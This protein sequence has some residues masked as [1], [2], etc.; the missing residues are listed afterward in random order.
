M[1]IEV[2]RINSQNHKLQTIMPKL[3]FVSLH[4]RIRYEQK[5]KSINGHERRYRQYRGRFDAS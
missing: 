2:K 5:R 3:I 1:L 4:R